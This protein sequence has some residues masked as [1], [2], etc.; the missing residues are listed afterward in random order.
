MS[1]SNEYAAGLFDGE[2]CFG[3]YQTSPNTWTPTVQLKLRSRDASVLYEMCERWGG[4]I[5]VIDYTKRAPMT[6]WSLRTFNG[7]LAFIQDVYPYLVLKHTQ[8]SVLQKYCTTGTQRRGMGVKV[9]TDV[10]TFRMLCAEA[11]S[12]LN[13]KGA[14]V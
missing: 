9:P 4:Q 2:G 10:S 11:L 13:R 7:V 5:R 1:V 3:L 8:A 14:D 12:F 6:C